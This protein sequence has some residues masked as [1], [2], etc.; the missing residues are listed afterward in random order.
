MLPIPQPIKT[1]LCLILGLV[2]L[3]ALLNHLGFSL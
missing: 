2:F 3:L 1:I